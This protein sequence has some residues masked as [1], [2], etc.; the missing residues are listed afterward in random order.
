MAELTVIIPSGSGAAYAPAAADPDGDTFANSGAERLLVMNGG[1]APITVVIPA[2][3]AIPGA[4]LDDPAGGTVP[5][6]G[7]RAF[8]KFPP[9]R[10]GGTVQVQY[11]DA[12]DVTVAVLK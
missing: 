6:G 5:A 4:G 10:F 3:A 8:G 2:T 12:T 11:S 7:A 9:T 1:D